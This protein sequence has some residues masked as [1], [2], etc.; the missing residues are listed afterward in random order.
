MDNDVVSAVRQV[1]EY[2]NTLQ[3]RLKKL[4]PASYLQYAAACLRDVQ[5]GSRNLSNYPPH[6]I[7]HSM[8]ANCAYHRPCYGNDVSEIAFRRIM[9]VYHA[10][11]DP[12][13]HHVLT[14]RNGTDKVILD[15]E[16]FLMVSARHQFLPQRSQ[17]HHDFARAALL[18]FDD[19]L[20]GTQTQFASKFGFTFRDWMDLCLLVGA[21]SKSGPLIVTPEHLR[22]FNC[23]TDN[24]ISTALE[25][26]SQSVD[27]LG[28]KFLELRKT[29]TPL[30]EWQIPSLLPERPLINIGDQQYVVSHVPYVLRCSTEG[31]YDICRDHFGVTFGAEFGTSFS[32]Y[33]GSILDEL[34]G[35]KQLYAE[36]SLSKRVV[37]PVC[38]YLVA[39][40]KFIMLVECKAVE[41]SSVFLSEKSLRRSNVTAKIVDGLGQIA[42][43]AAAV[44]E[45]QLL[46]L[47][48]DVGD[49]EIMAVV[50]TYREIF[51][52]NGKLYWSIFSDCLSDQPDALE[53]LSC[54]PWR[55]QILDIRSLEKLVCTTRMGKT[56]PELFADKVSQSLSLPPLQ[57]P[58]W[59]TYLN[60]LLVN[61]PNF[62]L[63]DQ[64]CQALFSE[65]HTRIN[66]AAGAT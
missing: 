16:Q 36:G 11:D 37:G 47:I 4:S 31:L 22:R 32:R 55:P 51:L 61:K 48:G 28:E 25:L 13:V 12:A 58:E 29:H 49:R 38:D 27:R 53:S 57:V 15:A 35:H 17:S 54:L 7:L 59:E 44:R 40:D 18:F 50:V 43:V 52:V 62:P 41:N 65:L 6:F 26:L 39:T 34:P 9:N 66:P 64:A 10:Y 56:L 3:R 42:N 30:V 2:R 8:E 45:G 21:I 33:V 24:V 5:T 23:F 46:D 14:E 19:T 20:K 1:E 63:L 60:G